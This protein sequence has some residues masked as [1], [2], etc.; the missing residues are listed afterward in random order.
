MDGK[1][2]TKEE[3]DGIHY[4][5]GA[6]SFKI[7]G[8]NVWVISDNKGF[9]TDGYDLLPFIV[10]VEHKIFDVWYESQFVDF[11]EDVFEAYAGYILEQELELT[12]TI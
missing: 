3:K 4:Y 10:S 1:R 8:C 2:L 5:M 7:G 11:G 9:I 12:E 6:P